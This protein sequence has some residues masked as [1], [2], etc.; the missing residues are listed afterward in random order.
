VGVPMC[1]PWQIE[2]AGSDDSGPCPCC[3]DVSRI[4][5]GIVQHE[6]LQ[7]AS[8]VVHWTLGHVAE[9]GAHFDLIVD[10][11]RDDTARIEQCAVS[12]A[13]RLI[14]NIPSFMVIDSADRDIAKSGLVTRPLN[15]TDIIG[16]PLAEDIFTICEVITAQDDRIAELLA[17]SNHTEPH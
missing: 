4:I 17:G 10:I 1:N 8:Y 3:G 13:C 9:H 7:I 12:L 5:R 16:D 2:A 14:D 15:R 6:G 11:W